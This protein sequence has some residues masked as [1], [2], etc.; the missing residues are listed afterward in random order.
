MN[1]L[2]LG[3]LVAAGL[4][5]ASIASA[6]FTCSTV[7][8]TNGSD[9]E[10]FLFARRFVDPAVNQAGDTVFLAKVKG[11]PIRFYL[12]PG[13]GAPSIVTRV[14]ATAPDGGIFKTFTQPSIND[15]G[16]IGFKARTSF[17][18][19]VFLRPAG[20][21]IEGA[22]LSTQASPGGG[23][24]SD[25][26]DASAVNSTRK[27]AFV[28]T[29][30]GGPSGVFLHD[31]IADTTTTIALAGDSIGGGRFLCDFRSVG[32]GSADAAF[33]GET[34]LDCN[35]VAEIALLGVFFWNGSTVSTIALQGD[36]APVAGTAYSDFEASPE[37]N[38][39]NHVVFRAE[40]TGSVF[41]TAEILFDPS[42]P[43]TTAPVT[44]GQAAP[45]TSGAI[46]RLDRQKITDGDAIFVKAN[47]KAGAAKNGIFAFDASPDIVALST[48]TPPTDQFG[49]GARYSKFTTIGVSRSGNQVVSVVRVKDT[50]T[51]RSKAGV[52][53]CVP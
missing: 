39:A 45:N 25:F 2:V 32:L 17:G 35:D 27:I 21:A 33:I 29:V 50:V 12:Y 52:V 10:S 28:A 46:G 38:A 8:R 22:A 37:M 43:T 49:V 3:V 1:R 34:K 40:L 48:D 13:V 20:G 51:P 47:I 16:D 19:G 23:F 9:P 26:V 11:S 30:S 31:G 41:V 15:A 18:R 44:T 5:P 4:V 53:R 42:G 6:S 7:A 14:N 36:T 24:F